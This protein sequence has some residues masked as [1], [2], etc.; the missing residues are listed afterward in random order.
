VRLRRAEEIE[1]L[2]HRTVVELNAESRLAPERRV[3][4]IARRPNASNGWPASVPADAV[5]ASSSASHVPSVP[6]DPSSPR[7][8]WLPMPAD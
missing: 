5:A 8:R 1:A 7:R 4:T 3:A 2:N 6:T